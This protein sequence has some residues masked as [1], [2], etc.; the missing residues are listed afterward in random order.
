M[1]PYCT[2]MEFWSIQRQVCWQVLGDPSGQNPFYPFYVSA[3]AC[4]RELVDAIEGDI[5]GFL[6][7]IRFSKQTSTVMGE[8][9]NK[10]F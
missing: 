5:S 3:S 8:Q 10:F 9:E 4:T 7:S 2:A 1:S 6:V